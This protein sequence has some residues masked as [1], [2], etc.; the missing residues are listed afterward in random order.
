VDETRPTLIYDGD[1]GFCTTAARWVARRW[2]GAPAPVAVPW[3]RV[4]VEQAARMHLS[5]DEMARSAWWSEGGRVE[6]GSRAVA[7][8]LEAT[9]G[10]WALV[11]RALL[12]PPISWVA[13]WGYRL[14]ARYRH[15]LPG[16]TPA[17]RV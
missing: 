9:D 11:G 17:C 15:R 6:E 12:V 5:A 13:P 8:A 14:V 4:P 7:R 3:Q 10:P 16:G 2:D 1:C